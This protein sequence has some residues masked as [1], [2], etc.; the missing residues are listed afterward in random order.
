MGTVT[1]AARRGRA[2]GRRAHPR[3]DARST[4]IAVDAGGARGRACSPTGREVRAGR[5]GRATPTRSACATWWGR[6]RFP[7]DVQRAARR[8]PA[9]RHD[10]QGEPGAEGPAALHLPARGPRPVRLD[11]APAA[12]RGRG[13]GVAARRASPTCR[14][15]E[16]AGVPDHRV[17][18][19]HHG[20]PVAARRRRATTTRRSSCSGC[21]TSSTG[22]DLGGRGGA[23]RRS[24]CCRSATA[25]RPGTSDLVVDTFPLHPQKIEE[26]FGI[27]ARAHPPRRQ[28]LRL[29]RPAALR[30]AGATGCTRR[31]PGCHP[32]GSV[33]GAAGHNAARRVLRDLGRA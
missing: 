30:D 8:L 6:A 17:V 22:H 31:A 12:R 1:A 20:R 25:S 10:L 3:P 28:H 27:T 7:A 14:P 16:L 2:R 11:H 4:R 21:R 15:G 9:R 5:G 32:A 18:H 13:D 29:R 26:H 19:P 24:T 33:I 23:L